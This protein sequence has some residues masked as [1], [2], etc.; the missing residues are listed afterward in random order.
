MPVEIAMD[1]AR[2]ELFDEF[3][4]FKRS[5]G[6]AYPRSSVYV[7]RRLSRHLA[8]FPNTEE[9][10]TRQ[11]AES[12]YTPGGRLTAGSLRQRRA[13]VRQ[14][15]LFLRWKGINCWIPPERSGGPPEPRC[16]PR[17]I[18]T[19]EMASV[20]SYADQVPACHL[21]PVA[22]TVFAALIR[23][24]WCCGLRIGE[25][26]ALRVGDV[27]LA[28]GVVTI[29]NGKGNHTRIVPMSASLTRDEISSNLVD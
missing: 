13:A 7:V 15:G 12:F 9:V 29:R 20:I 8:S 19:E 14:F 18:T 6:Y 3:V 1:G 5:L 24:L 21:S 28:A 16:T 27:D 26:V 11:A 2:P 23:M 22:H 10:M 4:A 17:I 25:A